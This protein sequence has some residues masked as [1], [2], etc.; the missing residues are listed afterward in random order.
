MSYESKELIINVS[1]LLDKD[2]VKNH[3]ITI[4]PERDIKLT[5]N[6]RRLEST[7][8]AI[9]KE[10]QEDLEYRKLAFFSCKRIPSVQ[11]ALYSKYFDQPMGSQNR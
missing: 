2:L 11:G 6:E 4:K 3:S 5:F 1:V 9:A 10:V 7:F 8:F